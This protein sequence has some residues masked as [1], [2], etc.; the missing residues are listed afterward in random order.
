MKNN[1]FLFIFLIMITIAIVFYSSHKIN[2][3]INSSKIDDKINNLEELKDKMDRKED[4]L[5]FV[6]KNNCSYCENIRKTISFYRD[7]FGLRFYE[8]NLSGISVAEIK[9]YFN[10]EKDAIMEPALIFIKDGVFKGI[11]NMII[12]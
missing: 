9:K 5:I 12:K 7:N 3:A 4:V 1:I 11:D 6:T 8:L 2:T 10:L